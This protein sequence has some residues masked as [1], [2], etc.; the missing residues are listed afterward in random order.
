MEKADRNY[1]RNCF[2]PIIQEF[3]NLLTE[4]LNN[5]LVCFKV[6]PVQQSLGKRNSSTVRTVGLKRS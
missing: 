1:T 3:R 6:I 5:G 4:L 2:L